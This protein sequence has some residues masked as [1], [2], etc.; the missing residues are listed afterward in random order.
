MSQDAIL[1]K[2]YAKGLAEQAEAV[3]EM[4]EVRNDLETVA[5]LLE[6]RRGDAPGRELLE[7][8]SAPAIRV[9]DKV[10]AASNILEAVGVGPTV[11]RFFS[12]LI[13][14]HRVD[15]LPHILEEFSTVASDLTGECTALVETARPLPQEQQGRRESV[16]ANALGGIVRVRQRV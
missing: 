15:V 14:H 6:N 11:T 3:G 7:F 9:E 1:A 8:L 10:A 16:L 5:T 12:L 4:A 2:R 13:R